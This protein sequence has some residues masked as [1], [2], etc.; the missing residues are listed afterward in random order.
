[1]TA[2]NLA[3]YLTHWRSLLKEEFSSNISGFLK[4]RAPAIAGQLTEKFP[5]PVMIYAFATPLVSLSHTG[6]WEKQF[7]IQKLN[8]FMA[9]NLDWSGELILKRLLNHI[10]TGAVMA[11]LLTV[12]RCEDDGC[13]FLL[14]LWRSNLCSLGNP[15]EI[16]LSIKKERNSSASLE[17]ATQVSVMMIFKDLPSVKLDFFP[18]ILY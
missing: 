3:K 11:Y 15:Q 5:N 7:D 2:Q 9:M 6:L 17:Y 12:I 16:I 8:M 18:F 13:R 10:I 4:R 14:N 1:M